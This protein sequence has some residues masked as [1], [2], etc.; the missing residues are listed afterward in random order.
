MTKASMEKDQSLLKVKRVAHVRRRLG[1]EVV[2]SVWLDGQEQFQA[3]VKTW[4]IDNCERFAKRC[5]KLDPSESKDEI[6]RGI[7]HMRQQLDEFEAQKEDNTNNRKKSSDSQ[8]EQTSKEQETLNTLQG[9]RQIH[10][11]SSAN[12]TLLS[13]VWSGNEGEEP[14]KVDAQTGKPV[15]MVKG[16]SVKDTLQTFEIIKH[17]RQLFRRHLFFHDPRTPLLLALWVL[18][19]YVYKEFIYYG[20][21]WVTSAV[22]GSGKTLLLDILSEVSADCPGRLSNLTEA[23]LFRLAHEGKTLI[24]DES[25]N[26]RTD[27]RQRYG[28]LMSVFNDGFKSGGKVPRQEKDQDGNFHTAYF[29]T[30]C[31]KVLAGLSDILDTIADRS[32]K[33][34][35]TKKTSKEGTERFN[36][37]MQNQFL[38]NLRQELS[39]WAKTNSLLVGEIYNDMGAG[40][41]RLASMDDRL[42]DITEPLALLAD[43]CDD[44]RVRT[45]NGQNCHSQIENSLQEIVDL[46]RDMSQTRREN[47]DPV[48]KGI[49]EVCKEMV[50]AEDKVFLSTETFLSELAKQGNPLSSARVLASRMER[51]QINPRSDGQKRGYYITR[52]WLGDIEQRYLGAVD[53]QGGDK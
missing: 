23:S 52:K 18:G 53:D 15:Y 16:W 24:L 38:L 5:V 10:V 7:T 17:L 47:I 8:P 42:V 33:I 29:N 44:E 39:R 34:V 14:F 32:F 3:K 48:V 50:G 9:T 49:I 41:G 45:F 46:L 28:A 25:E 19:T 51:L 20:Y 12:E 43:I 35:M 13:L 21:L 22:R 4:D 11:C 6:C 27:D 36:L 30:Y 2:L 26:L 37:R 31:P 40:Y 1:I